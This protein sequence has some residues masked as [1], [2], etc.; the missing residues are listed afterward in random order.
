MA[1]SVTPVS[2]GHYL[3]GEIVVDEKG[4]SFIYADRWLATRSAFALSLTMPLSRARYEADVL[5]P[6]LSNLLPEAL[7]LKVVSGRLGVAPGDVVGMLRHIG[8]DTAGAL[9]IGPPS[10]A[11]Q[12]DYRPVG[13]QA[14][15]ERLIEELPAKPFLVGEAGV[16]MSLA[17]VQDKLP[18]ALL[19]GVLAIPVNGAPSTHILK[20]DT[21]ERLFG[22][23]H[24]EA[25]CL[26]LAE[27]VGLRPH[28]LPRGGQV[29]AP[30]S[31]LPDM[32][33]FPLATGSGIA[34]IR[35]IS[36]RPLASHQRQNT[37]ITTLA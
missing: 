13:D 11:S 19:D 28:K 21:R 15:L 20:P 6:W 14:D 9:S 29:R 23:V 34:C 2:Y 10:S 22:S 30:I 7:A 27:M 16:S 3:V 33:G 25:L 5:V 8:Q 1:M 4:A 24:N 18:L 31:S 17:G 12:P 26:V 32:I 37:S 36:A 35:R